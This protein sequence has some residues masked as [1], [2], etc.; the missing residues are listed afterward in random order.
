[1]AS[2]EI[3]EPK[4]FTISW[5]NAD[6]SLAPQRA[7]ET[8]LR[9]GREIE[10]PLY[11]RR[12]DE[13]FRLDGPGEVAPNTIAPDVAIVEHEPDTADDVHDLRPLIGVDR[14]RVEAALRQRPGDRDVILSTV[15]A[16]GFDISGL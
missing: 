14:D 12:A 5:R 9:D 7:T 10:Q 8:V 16:N 11:D 3:T 13:P 4:H 6:G 2:A 15:E 1:L